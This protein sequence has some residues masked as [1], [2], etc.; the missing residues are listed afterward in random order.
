MRIVP[1]IVLAMCYIRSKG[2]IHSDRT[3]EYIVMDLDW[4]VEICS[5][6]HLFHPINR[7]IALPLVQT[8]GSFGVRSFRAVPCLRRTTTSLFQTHSRPSGVSERYESLPGSL[9]LAEGNWCLDIPDTVFPV[10]VGLIQHCVA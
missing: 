3:V 9:A 6:G 4:N 7:N 5:F 1:G 10:M 8:D 2:V